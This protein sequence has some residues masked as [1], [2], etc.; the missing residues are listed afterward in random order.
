MLGDHVDGFD[1]IT[2]R[3]AS[4][5]AIDSERS[6][7]WAIRLTNWRRP[8][9]PETVRKSEMPIVCPKRVHRDVTHV[10]RSTEK[11]R[12]SARASARP[13]FQ[14]INGIAI[15]LRKTMRRTVRQPFPV[16]AEQENRSDQLAARHRLHRP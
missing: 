2:A 8:A 7:H 12:G 11:S 5:A 9:G 6:D 1:L 3:V 4:C 14:P 13:D 10:D 16:G 15:A